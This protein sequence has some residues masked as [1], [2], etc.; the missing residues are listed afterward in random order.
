ML[1]N[2]DDNDMDSDSDL[3]ND[4]DNMDNDLQPRAD[5]THSMD[6][7]LRNVIILNCFIN[8]VFRVNSQY[9]TNSTK[10]STTFPE[11]FQTFAPPPPAQVMKQ[12]EGRKINK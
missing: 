1:R 4:M 2:Y 10:Q 5:I 11:H 3:T 8:F 7:L 6:A 9:S 12:I